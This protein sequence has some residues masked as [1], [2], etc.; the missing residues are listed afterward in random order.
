MWVFALDVVQGYV[1]DHAAIHELGADEFTHQVTHLF[2]GQLAGNR[3][4][5][6]PA[7]LGVLALLGGLDAVPEFGPVVR[8][9]GRIGRGQNLGMVHATLAGV[10]VD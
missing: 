2:G 10:V 7:K 3:Y 8:P 5:D 6:L 9:L 1:G 4:L